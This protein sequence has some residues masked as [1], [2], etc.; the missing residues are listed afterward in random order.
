MKDNEHIKIKEYF[1][2]ANTYRGFK[3]Y[4]DS[5]FRSEDFNRVYVL[6]GGPGTGKSSFM[7]KA[8]SVLSE[9]G[10]NIEKIYCSS[11]PRS[12][13]GIIAEKSD[14]KIAI[15]DGTAPHE[16]DAKIPGAIDELINLGVGWER[17]WLSARKKEILDLTKEKSY[18]YKTAYTY[19]S[20]AGKSHDYILSIHA[21]GFKKTKAKSK[22][23]EFLKDI[24][25]SSGRIDTRLIS[26]FGRYGKTRLD[27]LSRLS[28]NRYS[29]GGDEFAASLFL[30]MCNDILRDKSIGFTHFPQALD[31]SAT[32]AIFIPE[33]ALIV[34]RDADGKINADEFVNISAIDSER[35]KK[36]RQ[37]LRD[38]LDEAQRW[39]AIASDLH[40]RLEEIYGQAMNFDV[41]DGIFDSTITEINNILEK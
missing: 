13:D 24:N 2:A 17:N 10:C 31:Q 23:E 11:D 5:V 28:E 40:F 41:I 39:F 36:A 37:L 14:R 21:A 1:A 32:D 7:K 33:A 9:K 16:R 8:S 26:S 34:D 38:S 6:K 25:T 20:I 27:T 18:A 19:L 12:L 4:F 30:S 15:L 22:A 35:I 3:S 29:V